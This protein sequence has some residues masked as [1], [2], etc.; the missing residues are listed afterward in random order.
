MDFK[1]NGVRDWIRDF[2][3]DYQIKDKAH[4]VKTGDSENDDGKMSD[5]HP[6]GVIERGQN[7]EEQC[8]GISNEII[9]PTW[10][11]GQLE[12]IFNVNLFILDF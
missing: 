9:W 12:A 10:S 7:L 2:V 11:R 5:A 4:I 1:P 6:L 3:K 8:R